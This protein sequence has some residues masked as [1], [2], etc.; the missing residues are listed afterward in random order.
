MDDWEL[1]VRYREHASQEAFAQLVHRHAGLVYHACRRQLRDAHLAEDVSQA[2]FLLLARRGPA[3]PCPSVAAWLHRTAHFACRNAIKQRL[4]PERRERTLAA[5]NRTEAHLM[6]QSTEEE[7]IIETALASLSQVDRDVLFLRFYEDRELRQ[8]GQMLGISENAATKRLSRA[9]ERARKVLVSRGFNL[10]T[11]AVAPMLIS[12]LRQAAPECVVSAATSAAGTIASGSVHMIAKG[13]SGMMLA[14]KANLIAATIGGVV[15][16]IGALTVTALLAQ[17]PAPK[18]PAK[19][20]TAAA[21]AQAAATPKQV[22]K[23]IAAAV[24]SGD[25]ERVLA[26]GSVADPDEREFMECTSRYV[27]A[28]GTFRKAVAENFGAAA[29]N[30]LTALFELSPIG[31][32]GLLIETTVDQA[33]ESIEDDVARVQPEGHDDLT[34]WLVKIDGQWKLSIKRITEHWTRDEWQ[35]R[36]EAISLTAD[37][38]DEWASQVREGKY[39]KL[40]DLKAEV[41]PV[42][43]QNR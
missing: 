5:T 33:P 14:A 38:L 20:A 26:L 40:A 16:G 12:P 43:S 2:V 25:G 9:I 17:T 27:T 13:A 22:L 1:L 3:Q 11:N 32:F 19:A 37:K 30:E 31:R 15:L 6:V 42:L 41:G 23:A 39:A 10:P 36:V 34:F 28:T 35:T 29:A 4:R 18:E 21:P 8:V 24:R 7:A